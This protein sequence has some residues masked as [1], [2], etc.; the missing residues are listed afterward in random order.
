MHHARVTRE[1]V[2]RYEPVHHMDGPE[3]TWIIPALRVA[4]IVLF[5]AL[6][7]GGLAIYAAYS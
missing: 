1:D 6:L 2:E 5:V 7:V 3:N 4:A